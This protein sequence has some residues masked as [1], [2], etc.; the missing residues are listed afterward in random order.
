MLATVTMRSTSSGMGEKALGHRQI[1]NFVQGLWLDGFFRRATFLGWLTN[2]NDSNVFSDRVARKCS[3]WRKNSPHLQWYIKRA[4]GPDETERPE[5]HSKIKQEWQRCFACQGHQRCLQYI[6][7]REVK[8]TT[9]RMYQGG[10]EFYG[11]QNIIWNPH[12]YFKYVQPHV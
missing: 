8:L 2:V 12:A 6:K 10:Y 1:E 4:D 7:A 9:W 5:N 11:A 3:L